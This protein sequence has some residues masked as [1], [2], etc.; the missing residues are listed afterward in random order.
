MRCLETTAGNTIIA[1]G[2]PPKRVWWRWIT[3]GTAI[4]AGNLTSGIA[5]ITWL[6]G[7]KLLP[8]HGTRPNDGVVSGRL[9]NAPAALLPLGRM[10]G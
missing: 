2:I 7:R 10:S 6:P 1:I 9:A 8:W 5:L 4:N 3:N